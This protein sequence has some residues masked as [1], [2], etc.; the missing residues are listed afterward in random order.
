MKGQEWTA[1]PL[2][3]I[4]DPVRISRDLEDYDIPKQY[5]DRLPYFVKN[6]KRVIIPQKPQDILAVKRLEEKQRE[7]DALLY[8]SKPS[9]PTPLAGMKERISVIEKARE[10]KKFEIEDKEFRKKNIF[11]WRREPLM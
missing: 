3:S 5:R 10:S 9:P 1:I 4:V 7:R 6:I 11:V 8:Q 2:I